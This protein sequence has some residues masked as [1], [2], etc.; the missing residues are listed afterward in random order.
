MI[1]RKKS[2]WQKWMGYWAK[3][4]NYTSLVH[5]LGGMGFAWLVTQFFSAELLIGL[6]WVLVLIAIAGHIYPVFT[7]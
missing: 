6:G 3:H 1:F 5:F 7:E 2:G 4:P